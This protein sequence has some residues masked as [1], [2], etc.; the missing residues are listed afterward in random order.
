MIFKKQQ[1]IYFHSEMDAVFLSSQIS[2]IDLGAFNFLCTWKKQKHHI[3]IFIFFQTLAA[4]KKSGSGRKPKI[5]SKTS[6]GSREKQ[7]APK[8]LFVTSLFIVTSSRFGDN[9][10]SIFESATLVRSVMTSLMTLTGM[11]D[12]GR[13][14]T[15]DERD[16]FRVPESFIILMTYFSN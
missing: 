6:T 9:E 13:G 10:T 4:L 14:S 2:Q 8:H 15:E 16:N 3:I 11:R 5:F 7:P 1:I 12:I